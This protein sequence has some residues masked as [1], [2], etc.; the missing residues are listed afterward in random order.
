MT[1]ALTPAQILALPAMVD[2][3]QA[4][5]ALNIGK[6]LGYELIR[7]NEFPVEVIPFGRVLRVRKADLVA[8][9]NLSEPANDDAPG[10]RPGA[11]SAQAPEG[12]AA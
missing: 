8:F 5:A 4:F 2:A 3:K 6:T 7:A 11:E 1:N 10:L 9:L 12:A